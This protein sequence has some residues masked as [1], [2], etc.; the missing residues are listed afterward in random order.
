MNGKL[1]ARPSKRDMDDWAELLNDKSWN[2]SNFEQYFRKSE[3]FTPPTKDYLEKSNMTYDLKVYG[4]KGPIQVTYPQY[5]FESATTFLKGLDALGVPFKK[6]QANGDPI[7]TFWFP[8]SVR[9]GT[10]LRSYSKNEYIDPVRTKSNLHLLPEHAVTKIV[11]KGK[12]AVAVEV[13][14]ILLDTIPKYLS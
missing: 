7:G 10:Y 13:S 9:P 6:E 5:Y 11:F 4:N 2:W 12:T 1:W 3:T 8:G 14:G